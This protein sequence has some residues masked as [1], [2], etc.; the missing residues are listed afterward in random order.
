MSIFKAYDV[1][2]IYPLQINEKI[3]YNIGKAFVDVTKTKQVL[4]ARD[5]RASGEKLYNALVKGV[6]E[7][8][9]NV[10]NIGLTSTPMFYYAVNK[11]N[12][13]TG[14]IIT[15]SHNPTEYNGLKLVRRGAEPISEKTGIEEIKKR[16]EDKD[17]KNVDREGKIRKADVVKD[18]IKYVKSYAEEIKDLK[19]VIDCGNGMAGKTITCLLKSYNIKLVSLYPELDGSFP[20][21]EANPFKEEN[22]K[23]LQ[24]KVIEE[25][26]DIGF[27]FDGDADRVLIIDEKGRRV[28]GDIT[29]ALIAKQILSKSKEKIL[30][31]LRSSKAVPKLIEDNGG[32]PVISR[33][34]HSFIKETMRREDIAFAGE[35]SGHYYFKNNF[36]T[37]SAAIPVVMILSLLT[38]EKKK[39]SELVKNIGKYYHSGEINYEVKDKKAV[40]KKVQEHY[41]DAKINHIDG[42]TIEYKN[43]WFNLRKSNTEPVI[44]LNLE[45]DRKTLMKKKIKEVTKLINN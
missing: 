12:A 18:Y 6:T 17:Y 38:K 15:A 40:I 19:V 35:L 45:A 2:G 13:E 30:Y 21:H 41:K 3:V 32:T 9:A 31:D 5:M 10:I 11:L 16:V 28:P 8:G 1:R 42:V 20:N 14:I 25:K 33:V 36:Y 37:D 43:W 22:T 23:D 26:A 44:R 27:A 29:T 7:Q 34:G 24:K 39:V 4:I